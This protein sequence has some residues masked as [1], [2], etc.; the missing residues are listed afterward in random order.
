MIDVAIKSARKYDQECACHRERMSHRA[1]EDQEFT[2]EGAH[3]C[4]RC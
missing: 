3:M 2:E 1:C 4:D